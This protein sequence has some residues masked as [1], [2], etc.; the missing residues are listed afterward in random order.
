MI[1][2]VN[3]NVK[4]YVFTQTPIYLPMGFITRLLYD[5]IASKKR[6][7]VRRA[8][9]YIQLRYIESHTYDMMGLNLS[10]SQH[11]SL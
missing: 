10:T 5:H 4:V 9:Y 11:S 1:G 8:G 3:V 6:K 7:R 2:V